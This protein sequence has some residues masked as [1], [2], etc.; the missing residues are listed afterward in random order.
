MPRR[1]LR[2]SQ[3]A[4]RVL[5]RQRLAARRWGLVGVAI[6]LIVAALFAPRTA[7]LAFLA[8]A[9]FGGFGF[10]LQWAMRRLNRWMSRP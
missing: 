3:Y 2:S 7:L 8:L 10:A 4:N 6:A 5:Y 1:T 9:I